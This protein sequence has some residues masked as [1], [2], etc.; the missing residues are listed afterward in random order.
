MCVSIK[1]NVTTIT[2]YS[3]PLV[4]SEQINTIVA[5]EIAYIDLCKTS[6]EK[7]IYVLCKLYQFLSK[8]KKFVVHV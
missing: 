8:E 7:H 4:H 3:G 1:W 2:I 5:C 6:E